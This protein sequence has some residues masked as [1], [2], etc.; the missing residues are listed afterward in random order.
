MKHRKIAWQAA[1]LGCALMAAGTWSLAQGA[2]DEAVE[3]TPILTEFFQ[4]MADNRTDAL[5]EM[6]YIPA[7]ELGAASTAEFLQAKGGIKSVEVVEVN[8]GRG[9]APAAFSN[10]PDVARQVYEAK[11]RIAF[12]DGSVD[13]G[14]SVNLIRK[15]GRLLIVSP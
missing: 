8:Q 13:E 1:V 11:V 15:D 5:L 2:E 12:G 14:Q 9:Y 10:F 3:M 7:F 6:S 4:N